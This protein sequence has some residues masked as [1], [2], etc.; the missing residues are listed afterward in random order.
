MI[1]FKFF[2]L[3]GSHAKIATVCEYSYSNLRALRE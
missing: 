2:S 3:V 1:R